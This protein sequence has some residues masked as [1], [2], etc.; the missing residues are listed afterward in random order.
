MFLLW[1]YRVIFIHY[2]YINFYD[3]YDYFFSSF[4]NRVCMSARNIGAV[5]SVETVG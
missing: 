3:F 2:G 5:Q 1:F 4:Y